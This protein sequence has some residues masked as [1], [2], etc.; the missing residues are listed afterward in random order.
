MTK[1]EYKALSDKIIVEYG[2][3]EYNNYEPVNESAVKIKVLLSEYR[4][5]TMANARR[6]HSENAKLEREKDN[7]LKRVNEGLKDIAEDIP[8]KYKAY[9]I[10]ELFL[11]E[12]DLIPFN[13]KEKELLHE[14]FTNL[15]LS[16][17]Q[18]AIKCNVSTQHVTA[19]LNSTAVQILNQ[20]VFDKLLPLEAL[21][22]ILKALRANDSKVSLEVARHYKLIQNETSDINVISKPINDPEA[23]KM[24]KELGD[25]L[26]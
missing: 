3:P 1:E 8:N 18:L 20:K 21:K 13:E 10:P 16:N 6:A 14:H 17:K 12:S 11:T 26:A 23:I 25:K 19:L 24:L 15:T 7:N 22:S 2:K 4:M 5:S 9:A